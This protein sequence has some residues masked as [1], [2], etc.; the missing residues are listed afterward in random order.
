MMAQGEFYQPMLVQNLSYSLGL[1]YCA[2]FVSLFDLG[3]VGVAIARNCSDLTALVLIVRS[4]RARFGQ[5][6][7]LL[8]YQRSHLD[9]LREYLRISVPMGVIDYVQSSFYEV[10]TIIVGL[11][12]NTEAFAAHSSFSGIILLFY[13]LPLGLSNSVNSF[14]GNLIGEQK[15]L[16]A[17]TFSRVAQ[18]ATLFIALLALLLS[19][20]IRP[21]AFEHFVTNAE[22]RRWFVQIYNIYTHFYLFGDCFQV[23]LGAVLR[24]IGQQNYAAVVFGLVYYGIGLPMSLLLVFSAGLGALGAWWTLFAVSTIVSLLFFQQI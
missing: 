9:N 21:F 4:V 22:M 3:I 2:V 23:V 16:A 1:V 17:Q 7:G 19:E 15:H 11:T 24:S 8:V 13:M 10:Q 14:L 12:L 18:V 6:R 20:L 5:Y